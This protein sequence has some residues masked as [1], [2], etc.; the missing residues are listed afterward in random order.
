MGSCVQGLRGCKD[1]WDK[2][3]QLCRDWRETEM[4]HTVMTFEILTAFWENQHRLFLRAILGFI[5]EKASWS[6]PKKIWDVS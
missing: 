2:A 5:S 1:F 4:M 3:G 6:N